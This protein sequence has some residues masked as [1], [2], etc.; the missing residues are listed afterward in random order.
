MAGIK[1]FNPVSFPNLSAKPARGG[2]TPA[3]RRRPQGAPRRT[4][5]EARAGSSFRFRKDPVITRCLR[6][7]EGRPEAASAASIISLL[8]RRGTDLATLRKVAE[9][10]G[11]FERGRHA[12]RAVDILG[13]AAVRGGKSAIILS[14]LLRRSPRLLPAETDALILFAR[15]YPNIEDSE[16]IDSLGPSHVEDLADAFRTTVAMFSDRSDSARQRI[17]QVFFEVLNDKLRDRKSTDEKA[18]V[19]TAWA[20]NL[21]SILN[22]TAS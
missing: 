5:N 21:I 20:E 3:L 16:I 19:L 7:L 18:A 22:A 9:S 8:A 2:K 6:S 1:Y 10:I 14:T 11:S 15:I 13:R 17:E 4:R 12:S